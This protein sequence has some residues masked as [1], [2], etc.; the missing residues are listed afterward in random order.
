MSRLLRTAIALGFRN[1]VGKPGSRLPAL[2]LVTDPVRTPD[3]VATAGG[4]PRGAGLIYRS[5]GE[6]EALSVACALRQVANRRGLVFLIGADAGLATAAEADGVHL[7]ERLMSLAPG[8][9][10]AHPRWRITTAAHD[11]RAVLR[12]ARL[13]LDAAFLSVVFESR[14]PSAAAPL[15]PIRFAGLIQDA[16]LAVIALGGVND[17]TAPRLV[18]TGASGFAAVEGL[19]GR[20]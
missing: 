10:R 11:R 14:S 8:L 18:G 16:G 19:A 15:G 20:L 9:R 7:P 3:P 4:L 13:G 5:F 2:W 1:H 17:R 6:P 12:A